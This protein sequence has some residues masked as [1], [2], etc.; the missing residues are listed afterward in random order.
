MTV[1]RPTQDF[2]LFASR[3]L[4]DHDDSLDEHEFWALVAWLDWGRNAEAGAGA[5]APRLAAKVDLATLAGATAAAFDWRHVVEDT[6]GYEALSA[7]VP[8]EDGLDDLCF[9]VVGLG[10]RFVEAALRDPTEALKI[11]RDGAYV[12]S[13]R[14]VFTGAFDYYSE[15]QYRDEFTRRFAPRPLAEHDDVQA[16]HAVLLDDGALAVI[17]RRDPGS[18]YVVTPRGFRAIPWPR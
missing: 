16:T 8:S 17:V 12:E 10:Q 6:I 14:H 11:A 1:D 2:A 13:F 9:H 18:L 5:L 15:Q 3:L 7:A 4:Y